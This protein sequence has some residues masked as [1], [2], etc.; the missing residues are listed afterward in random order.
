MAHPKELIEN[1]FHEAGHQVIAYLISEVLKTEY[2]TIN[3]K[4]SKSQDSKSRGGVRVSIKK[5]INLLNLN[6]IDEIVLINFAGFCAD[7]FHKNHGVISAKFYK[8]ETWAPILGED[9]YEGDVLRIA[10]YLGRILPEIKMN[11]VEYFSSCIEFVYKLFK[12]KTVWEGVVQIK[13]ALLKE[14]SHTLKYEKVVEII[15]NTSLP[16]WKDKNIQA[17]KKKR[18]KLLYSKVQIS[19]LSMTMILLVIIILI[20]LYIINT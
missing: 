19:K 6:E 9:R 14:S 12:E 3:P 10:G 20:I 16:L 8:S 4:I 1:A 17:L 2:V 18:N 7:N 5:P 13:D 15:S 11:Q